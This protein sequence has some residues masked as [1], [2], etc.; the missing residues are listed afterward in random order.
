MILFS[1]CFWLQLRINNNKVNHYDVATTSLTTATSSI[2]TTIPVTTITT[3]ERTTATTATTSDV[4]TIVTTEPNEIIISTN[5]N[6]IAITVVEE[7]VTEIEIVEEEKPE[8]YVVY[9]PSTHY[10]HTNECRWSTGDAY[11]IDNTYDIECIRCNEC[12]PDIDIINEYV[13]PEP[14]YP[15]SDGLTYLKR[16]SRGTY[17]AYGCECYGGS[18][19]Y[20]Y[21]CSYGDGNSIKGSVAS[22]YLY[23]TLGYNYN[24]ER[25]KVYL[26]VNGYQNMDGWYY[27]DDSDAGNHNVIDFFYIYGS[28]CPFRNQGVV[29]VDCYY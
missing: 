9:K 20:L 25:T 5:T 3:T 24:G 7:P 6:T 8:P 14:E 26:E 18:G 23:N 22:S 17:Y 28:N 16:F 2:E 1:V 15:S 12:S 21:D 10:V 27:V 4:T 19:R 13:V 29:E 11:R